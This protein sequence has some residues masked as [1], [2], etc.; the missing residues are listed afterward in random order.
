MNILTAGFH[1]RPLENTPAEMAGVLE[2]YRQCEDFLALGPVAQASLEMVLADQALSRQ[3][4]G[5]YHVIA[6]ASHGEIVGVV[7]FVTAG[8]EGDPTLAFLGLLMIAAPWRGQGLGARVV[9]ALEEEI[10]RD[11]RAS[12]IRSGV[13]VSNPAA[14]RFW[15]RMGFAILSGPE[16]L[17][18][19][20]R[21][22][23][24]R[25]QL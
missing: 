14:I 23:Q 8:F 24:L 3:E 7:D 6:G 12:A 1:I 18:D 20:T 25:K 13:Q 16:D 10:R 2:V 22:Y 15:L 19:G 21:V 5:V 9:Q 11:G 17:P 4:G